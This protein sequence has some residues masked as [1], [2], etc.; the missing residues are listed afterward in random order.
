M[1]PQI[2]ITEAP[3]PDPRRVAHW[4]AR[5]TSIALDEEDATRHVLNELVTEYQTPARET[6]APAAALQ[7]NPALA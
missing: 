1:H 3:Q 2:V 5:A 4:L 7:S 6:G